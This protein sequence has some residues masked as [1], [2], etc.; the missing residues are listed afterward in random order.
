MSTPSS[1][2]WVDGERQGGLPLP[3]RGLDYGD[4]LFETLLIEDG[5]ALFAEMHWQRLQRGLDVLRFPDC[6]ALV[7]SRFKQVVDELRTN[8]WRRSALRITVTRGAGPRGYTPPPMPTP[9]VIITAT[10]LPA[11]DTPL[12]PAS[13]ILASMRWASQ[14]ALSG[15]KHLNRLEQVLAAA[16]RQR[17]GAD[18]ALMLGQ[19]GQLVS[20]T[21]GNLFIVIDDQINTPRL[22]D[23][24]IAG[25]RRQLVIE[26]W[27]PAAGY[28]VNEAEL[29]WSALQAAREVFITNTLWGLRPV[30]SLGELHWEKHDVCRDLQRQYRETPA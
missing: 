9:R 28:L 23:C 14:P 25:T 20:V 22:D 27:A 7:K 16:E 18:E 29:D 1:A 12:S 2:T 3:D 5:S 17:A 8:A 10:E 15:I 11:G 24:G 19:S 13:L 21:S 4:G 30:A 26:R 6:L